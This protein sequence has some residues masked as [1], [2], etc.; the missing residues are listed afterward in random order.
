MTQHSMESVDRLI[1][2]LLAAD[3]RMSF[4]DL[5]KKTGAVDLSGPPAGQAAGA[6]RRDQGLRGQRSTSPRSDCR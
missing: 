5:G 4:T 2:Q 3:G 6:A 1:C